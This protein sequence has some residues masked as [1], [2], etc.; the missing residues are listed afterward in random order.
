MRGAAAT[1]PAHP[2]HPL[3]DQVDLW[4]L[5]ATRHLDLK[6][7][8]EFGQFLTPSPVA[9]FMASLFENFAGEVRLLDAGAGAGAL[10]VAA[11]LQALDRERV[12]QRIA[13]TGYEIDP[14]FASFLRRSIDALETACGKH[15]V[16]FKAE[17]VEGDFIEA[18]VDILDPG[19]FRR[20][21]TPGS[22]T[23]F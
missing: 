1:I 12:P 17:A 4:R 13:V 20:A 10:L 3:L 5:E 11:T 7:R 8:S 18:A 22:P 16:S 19:L 15:G 2:A 23:P 14:T 6:R 9:S 21:R